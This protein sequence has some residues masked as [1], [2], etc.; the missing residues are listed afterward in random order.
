VCQ[1]GTLLLRKISSRISAAFHHQPNLCCISSSAES[2]LQ[3]EMGEATE[4][5]KIEKPF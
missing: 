4:Q 3:P 1:R 2:L 5:L